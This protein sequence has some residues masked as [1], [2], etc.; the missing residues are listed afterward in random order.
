MKKYRIKDE[1]YISRYN[2]DV[3][4][5]YRVQV[6]SFIFFYRDFSYPFDFKADAIEFIKRNE[7]LDRLK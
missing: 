7:D 6:R 1:S 5:R 2:G 3:V 4:G